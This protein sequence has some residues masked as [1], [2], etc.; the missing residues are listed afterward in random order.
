LFIDKIST[1]SVPRL[2]IATL[3]SGHLDKKVQPLFYLTYNNRKVYI[4]QNIDRYITTDKEKGENYTDKVEKEWRLNISRNYRNLPTT[5]TTVSRDSIAEDGTVYEIT[6]GKIY[7]LQWKEVDID[8]LCIN[9]FKHLYIDNRLDSVL[10]AYIDYT[11]GHNLSYY[12][13]FINSMEEDRKIF[14]PAPTIGMTDELPECTATEST[15]IKVKKEE[16]MKVIDDFLIRKVQNYSKIPDPYY[17]NFPLFYCKID[18]QYIF[19]YTGMEEFFCPDM[20][21]PDISMSVDTV[22][23]NN[24]RFQILP[25]QIRILLESH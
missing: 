17:E 11:K 5:W 8:F 9:N 15:T 12:D 10:C 19:V 3:K 14:F 13:L 25:D 20:Q 23:Y 21:F 7:D 24:W 16:T 4:C 6:T 2:R 18:R 22:Y 1:Y